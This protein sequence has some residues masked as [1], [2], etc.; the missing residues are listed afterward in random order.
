MLVLHTGH[1]LQFWFSASLLGKL[2]R[3]QR[4]HSE[5]VYA[6]HLLGKR[7]IHQTMLLQQ[8]ETFKPVGDDFSDKLGATAI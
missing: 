5:G 4:L 6:C 1:C 7:F 8:G 2:C 3:R